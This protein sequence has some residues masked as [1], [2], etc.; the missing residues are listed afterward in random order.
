MRG[1]G[2]TVHMMLPRALTVFLLALGAAVQAQADAGR[3]RPADRPRIAPGDQWHFAAY[4]SVPTAEPNRVWR[5][6]SVTTEEIAG[7]ENGEPLRLTPELNVLESP[8]SLES[9]P[10]LLSFPLAVGKRWRFASDWLF[11]QK[12]SRGRIEVDVAVLGHETV[13]VPA[14]RF[15]AFK[16][17]A[18]GRLSGTSPADS[19]YD[20]TTT[21]TYWYSPEARAIVKSVY[22]NPYLGTSTVDLVRHLPAR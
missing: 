3:L 6:V 19:R 8:R 12:G 17:Q 9:N 5:I 13:T 15:D 1:D 18:T 4:G 2:D 11:K 16:L 14:G 21:T 7:T 22:H 20:A 10:R